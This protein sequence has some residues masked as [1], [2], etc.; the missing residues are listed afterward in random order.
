M[1]N[2]RKDFGLL[3]LRVGIGT[4]FL[5]HGWPKLIGGT[6]AW[7]N[8]GAATANFG[9]TFAPVVFGLLA[10]LA[11]FFGGLFLILGIFF[12][13][14]CFF[15]GTTMLVAAVMHI[16][17]GD[18]FPVYSHALKVLIICI[19]LMVSGPGKYYLKLKKEEKG[20]I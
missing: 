10:A 20:I 14:A 2:S 4:L 18:S 6:P 19:A 16:S 15:L 7:E 9:I 5:I 3:I 11:E 1:E 12:S 8:L 13:P 17:N